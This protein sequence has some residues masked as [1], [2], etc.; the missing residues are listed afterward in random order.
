MVR[1]T[2]ADDKTLLIFTEGS[3]GNIDRLR[4][5]YPG[6]GRYCKDAADMPAD[7][8]K[9]LAWILTAYSQRIAARRRSPVSANPPMETW[10]IRASN[11]SAA[12]LSGWFAD[13]KNPDYRLMVHRSPLVSGTPS[14][15]STA[16]DHV[17]DRLPIRQR[18]GRYSHLKR[19]AADLLEQLRAAYHGSHQD[20]VS[21]LAATGHPFSYSCGLRDQNPRECS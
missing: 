13:Q 6:V 14:W 1:I 11:D 9:A 5:V 19:S 17:Y 16:W 7:H 12:A 18:R 15:A 3:F 2:R 10:V 21:V 4:Q 8:E 20:R